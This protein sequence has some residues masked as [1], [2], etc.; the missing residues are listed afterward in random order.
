LTPARTPASVAGILIG[1]VTPELL[2]VRLAV[3]DCIN[4]YAMLFDRGQFDELAELFAPDAIFDVSPAPSFLP[5]PLHGRDEIIRNI[6][7]RHAQTTAT[8]AVHQHVST[9]TVFDEL[10]AARC[11][12]RTYLTSLG[13]T[14]DSP[15]RLLT[16]GTYHDVFRP[17]GDR[18]LFAERRLRTETAIPT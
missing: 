4:W 13:A 12:T 18:W 6:S 5:V 8:G 2:P 10:T 9:N 7:A 11:A 1:L 17:D 3:Q 16:I 14:P 15:A